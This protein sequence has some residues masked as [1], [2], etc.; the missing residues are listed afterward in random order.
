MIDAGGVGVNTTVWALCCA[1]TASWQCKSLW[2]EL[3]C[4]WCCS[5]ILLGISGEPGGG[6]SCRG[7]SLHG[8]CM[9]VQLVLISVSWTPARGFFCGQ[10][11]QTA[12]GQHAQTVLMRLMEHRPRAHSRWSPVYGWIWFPVTAS[13]RHATQYFKCGCECTRYTRV[14]PVHSDSCQICHQKCLT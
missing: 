12:C 14:L 13:S 2:I 8:G 3:M 6:S 10:H 9:H 1:P 7:G 4:G 11:A 5:S